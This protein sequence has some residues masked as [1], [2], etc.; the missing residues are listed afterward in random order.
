VEVLPAAAVEQVQAV[1]GVGG[2]MR[3]NDVHQHADAVAV[4]LE[5][6]SSRIT[7]AASLSACCNLVSDYPSHGIA[8]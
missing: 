4:R 1:Q 5:S 8:I 7:R 2:G 3:V 6:G